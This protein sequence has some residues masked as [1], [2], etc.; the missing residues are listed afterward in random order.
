MHI[1]WTEI[2]IGQQDFAAVSFRKSRSEASGN[3]RG[4]RFWRESRHADQF[5][6]VG[7][8]VQL[9]VKTKPVADCF[10]GGTDKMAGRPWRHRNSSFATWRWSSSRVIRARLKLEAPVS[11]RIRNR[12]QKRNAELSFELKGSL[13]PAIKQ[14]VGKERECYSQRESATC[15]TKHDLIT[16][17][18]DQHWRRR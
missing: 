1:S 16:Y 10:A 6:F 9:E 14:Q 5:R 8:L 13:D 18:R 4:A 7:E 11:A 12:E 15:Q 17:R 3:G 2:R